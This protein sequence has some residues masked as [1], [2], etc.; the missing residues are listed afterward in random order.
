MEHIHTVLQ[1]AKEST[2]ARYFFLCLKLPSKEVS[3]LCDSITP[4][5]FG[6]NWIPVV[7]VS[8]KRD[9]QIKKIFSKSFSEH[10]ET[11]VILKPHLL[12]RHLL[13]CYHYKLINQLLLV[14]PSPSGVRLLLII[15]VVLQ[16]VS[17]WA[18]CLV[19]LIWYYLTKYYPQFSQGLCS[20]E[21]EIIYFKETLKNVC[22]W[23]HS[24]S[25]RASYC[26]SSKVLLCV[27]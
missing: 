10:I 5:W 13:L 15:F 18:A 3:H 22:W 23:L 19:Q 24:Y 11:H 25:C 26:K 16:T 12:L 6:P 27:H 1:G 17:T 7:N 2:S 9:V 4:T 14:T 20:G 8:H 21:Q